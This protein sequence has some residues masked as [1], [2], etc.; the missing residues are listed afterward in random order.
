[1]LEDSDI[2]QNY[3]VYYFKFNIFVLVLVGFDKFQWKLNK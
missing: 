2:F 1:M 3:R